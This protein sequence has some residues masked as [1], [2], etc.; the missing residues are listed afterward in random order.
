MTKPAFSQVFGLALTLLLDVSVT[1]CRHSGNPT[2]VVVTHVESPDHRY[3]ALWETTPFNSHRVVARDLSDGSRETILEFDRWVNMY[4]SPEG[5][6]IA[7]NYSSASNEMELVVLRRENT[8]WLRQE[9][10]PSE[11][12]EHC[13][14]HHTSIRFKK[15]LDNRT[16]L[17]DLSGCKDASDY[18]SIQELKFICLD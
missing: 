4:W 9:V 11:L 17:L 1:G 2:P 10:H 3:Q 15:W 8:R 16:V 13:E 5:D 14:Y 6:K 12:S 18:V 7:L